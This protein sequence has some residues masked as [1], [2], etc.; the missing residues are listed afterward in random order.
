LYGHE[1]SSNAVNFSPSG[2]YF[3]SAGADSIVMVWKSN[4]SEV[5]VEMIDE[6]GS[7]GAAQAT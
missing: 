4:L 2:D 5:E 1:G 3:C 6:H 7:K